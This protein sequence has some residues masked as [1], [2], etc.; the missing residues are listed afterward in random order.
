MV[1]NV[2]SYLTSNLD[3]SNCLILLWI[4]Q[5]AAAK[6]LICDWNVAI[7]YFYKTGIFSNINLTL[8]EVYRYFFSDSEYELIS[9][10][11]FINV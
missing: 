2:S 9:L 8:C 3:F 10:Y 7:F 11:V 6:M 1:V 4:P 5:F